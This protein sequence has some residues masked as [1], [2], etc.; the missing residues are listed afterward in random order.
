MTALGE[1]RSIA[2]YDALA[3]EYDSAEHRATRELERL[4]GLALVAAGILERLGPDPTLVELGSGTGALS[5]RIAVAAAGGCLL[6]SDPAPRMLRR[7]E[8]AV[9]GL[10]GAA[11]VALRGSAVEILGR[12]ASPPSAIFAG[13][14]DPYLGD[15]L[16]AAL[17]RACGPET[18]VFCSVPS[19][20]WAVVERGRRLG[21]ALDQTRFRTQEGGELYSRSL[22]LDAEELAGLFL[23][24]GF[25]IR[26]GGSEPAA[27]PDQDGAPEVAWVA[28]RPRLAPAPA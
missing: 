21:I 12:L 23:V 14:A 13:L 15:P 19:R 26:G 7:A 8:S 2:T 3:A 6:L 28:A 27:S 5:R 24:G 10:G 20:R 22:C 16:L 4:S 11:K 17:R 9:A 18:L 25:E 1:A